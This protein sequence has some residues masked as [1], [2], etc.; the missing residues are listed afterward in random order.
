MT[1]HTIEQLLAEIRDSEAREAD[2]RNR[3]EVAEAKLAAWIAIAE[4]WVVVA[5]LIHRW[6]RSHD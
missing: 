6:G 2:Y 3:A 1:E 5:E 4:L